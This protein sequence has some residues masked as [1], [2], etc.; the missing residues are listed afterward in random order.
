MSINL[1]IKSIGKYIPLNRRNNIKKSRLFD[2][3]DSFVE[4]KIGVLET[5]VKN[6]GDFASDMA[7]EA[8]QDLLAKSTLELEAIDVLI[9]VTQN[10]DVN[11]PHVSARVHGHFDLTSGCACFD[12]SLGCSGFVY[13]LS[14]IS[15]FM[16]Q[17]KLQ[18]GVLITSDP[19]SDIIDESDK[20]TSMIFGDAAT[21]SWIGAN[22]VFSLDD[23]TF[24][25]SGRLYNHLIIENSALYMNGRGI[26]NFV[27]KEVPKDIATLLER[28]S[29]DLADIEVFIFHQGSKYIVDTLVKRLGVSSEK[30]PFRMTNYGN[31]VSS[32]IPLILDEYFGVKVGSR[33]LLSGFGVGLSWSSCLITKQ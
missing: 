29:L 20:N 11:I 8:M 10:P 30:V 15:S 28:S 2:L 17:N 3:N 13:A 1:G 25:T 7:I 5:A 26:F 21:A 22:P 31:T 6:T 18:N 24:G 14:I 12:V 9:V 33:L 19:Y 4:N 23:F 16:R 32:S 27:A